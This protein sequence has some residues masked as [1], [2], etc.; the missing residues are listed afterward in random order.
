MPERFAPL[1]RSRTDDLTRAW[2]DELYA[3]RRTELPVLLSYR[4]LVEHLPELFE[5]LAHVL[6]SEAGYGEIEEAVR[7]LRFHA[8][9]RFQQGCL[10]DEVARELMTLRDVLNDFLWREGVGATEGDILALRDALRRANLF[11]DEL[12]AQAILIY[13]ASLR[14]RVRTRAPTWPPPDRRT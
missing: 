2:V 13:A 7:R 10:I 8:Q 14:P 9:V 12:L 5:E 11:A 1:F 4:E 6:D 3:D